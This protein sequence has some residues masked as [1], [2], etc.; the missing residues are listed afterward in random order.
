M[1]SGAKTLIRSE[2][3]VCLNFAYNYLVAQ[4]LFIGSALVIGVVNALIEVLLTSSV[5]CCMYTLSFAC[6]AVGAC[7]CE[8]PG[9]A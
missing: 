3:D 8:F 1:F 2:G 4:A 9:E 6:C 7:P 5:T